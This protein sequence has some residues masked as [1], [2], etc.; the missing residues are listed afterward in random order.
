MRYVRKHI[1]KGTWRLEH[2]RVET[3]IMSETVKG[4][5]EQIRPTV[6]GLLWDQGMYSELKVGDSGPDSR[7][8]G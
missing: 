2:P 3:G 4:N 8:H 1:R 7:Q 6:P 5:I